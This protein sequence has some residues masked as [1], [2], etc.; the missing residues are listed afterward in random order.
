MYKLTKNII[1]GGV[2]LLVIQIVY[3]LIQTP[4]AISFVPLLAVVFVLALYLVLTFRSPIALKKLDYSVLKTAL[5]IGLL[6][7]AIYC[8]Q[9]VSEYFIPVTGLIDQRWGYIAFGA[10]PIWFG[11]AGGISAYKTKKFRAGIVAAIWSAMISSLLWINILFVMYF[12]FFGT[13]QGYAVL[14]AGETIADF[15][16]SGISSL[17]VF[18]MQDFMGATFFH[19]LL[20]I[21]A[22]IIF[23]SLG[24]LISFITLKGLKRNT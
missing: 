8:V 4:T 2:A 3:G 7:S 6:I 19:L 13:K 17:P 16:R 5:V 18:V 15:E 10:L 24:A 22:A 1:I 11:I 21:I 20:S 9:I 23:G 14:V 12:V